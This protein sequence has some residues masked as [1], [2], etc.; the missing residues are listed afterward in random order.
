MVP[1]GSRTS[2]LIDKHAYGLFSMT[3]I[4]A[5]LSIR[6]RAPGHPAGPR[7]RT[8]TLNESLYRQANWKRFLCRHAGPP[9]TAQK[10]EGV[11][12][13]GEV[14]WE[15][16]NPHFGPASE[17]AQ[18]QNNN[19]FRIYRYT[20]REIARKQSLQLRW[21]LTERRELAK[22]N[23]TRLPQAAAAP[24]HIPAKLRLVILARGLS[25]WR[26]L[27]CDTF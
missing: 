5:A 12:S 17:P 11:T 13:D 26:P 25:T 8:W 4:N 23:R 15:Y 19:V 10:R 6:P 9:A 20:E 3:Y 1:A 21:R 22:Q 2:G 7:A 18:A 27:Y 24:I 16:V 14:V